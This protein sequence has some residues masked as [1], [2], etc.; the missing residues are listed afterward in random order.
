MR[1]PKGSPEPI[2]LL[3]RVRLLECGEP[4]VPLRKYCPG[5]KILRGTSV[6][7][8]RLRVAQ[9]LQRARESLWPDYDI[10]VRE[11]WRSIERQKFIYDWY[12]QQ[13]KEKHP[14]W[15]HA[16]LRRMTNRFFAPYDQKAPPGHSTGGAIDVWLL[17]RKRKPIDLHGP[18]ERFES[19]P[20]FAAHLP[21]EIL[22]LRYLLYRALVRQ[23][24]TN[25]RDEWWHYSFGDAAWAVRRGRKTCFYGAI[26]PPRSVYAK[27]D[28]RFF[29]EFLQ[30]A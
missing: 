17:D 27:K 20:T 21:P 5:I 19:A 7:Y 23:G 4:L 22:E 3:N 11:A 12:F 10:G 29:R 1:Y 24:F 18:G 9:M 30:R 13:L 14:E 28:E 25:C 2:G 6:P 8:A 26:A 16:T 15:S